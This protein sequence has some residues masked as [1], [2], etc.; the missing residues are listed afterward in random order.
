MGSANQY[1]NLWTV[2]RRTTM[3][4]WAGEFPELGLKL[5]VVVLAS[6]LPVAAVWVKWI[7]DLWLRAH[8]IHGRVLSGGTGGI[9]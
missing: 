5:E 7:L 8:Q 3:G 9:T 4:L 2:A 1:S 6:V